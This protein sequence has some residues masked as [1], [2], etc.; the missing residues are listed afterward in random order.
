MIE[1]NIVVYE[2]LKNTALHC[3]DSVRSARTQM[4]TVYF[5]VLSFGFAYH[6]LFLITFIILI[7]F[8]TI[9]NTEMMAIE[10]V[11]SYIRVFFEEKRNDMHWS[12]L[13]KD[14]TH[15]TSYSKQYKNIGWYINIYASSFFAIVSL[16]SMIIV[17]INQDYDVGTLPISVW[18]QLGL[19]IPL[20]ITAIVINTKYY[21]FKRGKKT[22][23]TLDRGIRAFYKSLCD[24][25][26]ARTQ[27]ESN[28]NETK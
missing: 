12:L 11:S 6:W 3:E 17:Y 25:A 4:Y 18:I 23:E 19:A 8:Q 24:D 5:A 28:S 1:E 26:A 7:A 2:A 10:R 27:V 14:T 15:L 21:D 13:N 16:I 22:I 20:C 9:I